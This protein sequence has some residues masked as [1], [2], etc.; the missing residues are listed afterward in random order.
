MVAGKCVEL[1]EGWDRPKDATGSGPDGKAGRWDRKD[2]ANQVP[3]GFVN[4]DEDA[5]D[6]TIE[7]SDEETTDDLQETFQ[8]RQEKLY[9]RLVKRWAK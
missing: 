8:R 6:E 5:D 4:E 9:E 3:S 1:D 2:V 7:E